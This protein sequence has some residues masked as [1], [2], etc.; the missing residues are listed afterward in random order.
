M[1][2]VHLTKAPTIN[3]YRSDFWPRTTYYKRDAQVLL[4]GLRDNGG[5][6]EIRPAVK[7][8]RGGE[9]KQKSSR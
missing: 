8:P 4:A 2:T 3:P 9:K 1:W 6:G 7:P 5:D